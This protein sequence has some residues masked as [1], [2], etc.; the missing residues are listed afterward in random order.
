MYFVVNYNN[1]KNGIIDLV[2]TYP[3]SITNEQG[4]LNIYFIVADT[5]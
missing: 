4:I 3:I 2:Q 1:T 5:K